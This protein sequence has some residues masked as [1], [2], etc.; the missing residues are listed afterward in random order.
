MHIVAETV[1]CLNILRALLPCL[2][3]PGHLSHMDSNFQICH[4][5]LW[6]PVCD[7]CN[8]SEKHKI[9]NLIKSSKSTQAS[10]FVLTFHKP[11]KVERKK[12]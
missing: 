7:K 1:D 9:N 6:N 2:G 10:I 12:I 5:V 8:I 4:K 3:N 11:Q